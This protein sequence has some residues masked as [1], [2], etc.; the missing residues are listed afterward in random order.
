MRK[1]ISFLL[2]LF[3]LV[4][5]TGVSYAWDEGGWDYAKISFLRKTTA[6]TV[7]DYNFQVPF[8]W[9]DE[10]TDKAYLLVDNSVSAA[11]WQEI[12]A[13]GGSS[14]FTTVDLT[15]VPDTNSPYMQAAGAGFGE[16]PLWRTD[17]DTIT[18]RATTGQ[19]AILN[20]YSDA[21]EDNSD[22]WRVKVAD[23]GD[24]TLETYA[25]GAWV[26]VGTWSNA[27]GFTATGTI[28]GGTLTEGG[29]AVPNATDKLSFFAATTSE[30]LAGVLSD[31]TGS[32]GGFVRATSPT[33]ATPTITTSATVPTL[34]GSSASGGD[35]TLEGSSHATNGDVLIQPTDGFTAVGPVTPTTTFAVGGGQSVKKT[36]VADAAYG[37]SALTTDYIVSW[38][39]LTAARAAVISTED[40]ESGTATQPRVIVL[41]DESGN[42][43]T[44]NVTITLENSGTIDGAASFVINQPYQSVTIYLNGSLGFVY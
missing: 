23:G 8:L 35:L 4:T 40:V 34:Y 25:S 42:A 9:I 15:G 10:V 26:A 33:I 44:Y 19:S 29:N 22:K 30:E 18:L 27:G 31:E 39:S 2:A 43:G 36:N 37:T 16:S 7:N 21:A 17:A 5:F 20:L 1:F 38:T 41:K 14:S 3:C 32:G 28:A 24:V 6:P 13:A 11:V 12:T